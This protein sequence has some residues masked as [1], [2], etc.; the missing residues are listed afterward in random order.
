MDRF[1]RSFKDAYCPNGYHARA[2]LVGAAQS[3]HGTAMTKASLPRS[4]LPIKSNFQSPE[5]RNLRRT[6]NRFSCIAAHQPCCELISPF[7]YA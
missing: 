6:P 5:A 1:A 4:D 3:A 2:N 7:S